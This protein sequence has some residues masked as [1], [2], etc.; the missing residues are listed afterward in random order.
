MPQKQTMTFYVYALFDHQAVPRYIGKGSGN[1]I[2]WSLTHSTA[3][4]QMRAFI[5]RTLG[6][7]KDIPRIKIRDRLSEAQAFEIERTLIAAL[8]RYPNGPLYN[9]TDGGDGS[10]GWIPT[11]KQKVHLI[12][13]LAPSWTP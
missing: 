11:K 10:K 2:N 5:K 1:R 3:N 4:F 8:G 12:Q 7:I 9:W 13:T 6:K